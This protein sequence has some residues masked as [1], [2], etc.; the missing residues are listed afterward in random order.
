VNY[1]FSQNYKYSLQKQIGLT[2]INE[3]N[4]YL[5]PTNK[6]AIQRKFDV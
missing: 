1:G 5:T 6:S 2:K 3:I 4:F